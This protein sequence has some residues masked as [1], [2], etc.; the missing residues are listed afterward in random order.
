MVALA[1]DEAAVESDLVPTYYDPDSHHSLW[2]KL[3]E[4]EQVESS[5]ITDNYV[6]A[7]S[8]DPVT[9]GGLGNQTPLIIRTKSSS[10]ASR[11]FILNQGA[12][13]AGGYD[14]EE[15]RRYHWT[16][17]SSGAWKQLANSPS[18]RFVYYRPGT[19][20][21]GTA[22]T[23][24]GAGTVSVVRT[25]QRDS[26]DHFIGEITDYQ[27][28]DSPVP[29]SE[30]PA[31][32]AQTSI[33][34]ITKNEFEKLLRRGLEPD[35]VSE[36]TADALRGQAEARGLT[37]PD[38]LYAQIVATLD[39]GKHIILTGPPG[40]AKTTL[41]QAV[42]A[43]AKDAG[44]TGG[45]VL[46]TATADW[47]TFETI[48]GLRPTASG[49]LEFEEGHFLKAIRDDYWLVIDEL[50]RSNFDRAFGQ[51]FTVLS[52]QAVVLPYHRPGMDSDRPLVLVPDGAESPLPDGDILSIPQ[53][54]RVLAT[55]NVFDKT[56]L[57]EMS[58]ALMRRFAFIEVGSPTPAV[59]EA[60]IEREAAGDASSAAIAKRML[61]L[62]GLKDLGP[63]VFMDIARFVRSRLSMSPDVAAEQVLYESFYGFLLPQFEGIDEEGGEA[64]FKSVAQLVGSRRREVLRKT[65]NEVLGLQLQAPTV[66]VSEDEEPELEL[67]EQPE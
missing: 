33:Q 30:G 56:L 8:G 14:D 65:L 28:F 16:S 51:L 13:G 50:N 9:A 67:I 60:L 25:E 6:L 11:Y 29:W 1:L 31:R 22:K 61:P 38:E 17:R 62:R 19:A 21:D 64:L 15:G 63:A 2:V 47:T 53:T 4:F 37:L 54:W 41:A 58:F 18:A 42:A 46:T 26:V 66:E 52:G 24:F 49:E 40:T 55:M 36:F 12:N 23:Y 3:A 59:F 45:Y 27:P 39:S 5:E 32:N 35:V 34:P 48:G 20:S 43:A 44:R 10:A 7:Q 57:F